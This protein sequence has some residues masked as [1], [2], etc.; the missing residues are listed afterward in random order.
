M[1]RNQI[2]KLTMFLS[3]QNFIG[4]TTEEIIAL[5]PNF[6]QFYNQFK[7][8][9]NVLLQQSVIQSQPILGYRE[10]KVAQQNDM[11]NQALAITKS[12]YAYAEVTNNITLKAASSYSKSAL[13]KVPEITCIDA[14][15]NIHKLAT[16]NISALEPYNITAVTIEKLNTAIIAFS[17]IYPVPKEH[18]TIKKMATSDIKKYFTDA[19]TQ[20]TTM[21]A[22][23]NMLSTTQPEFYQHYFLTRK[24]EKPA[25]ITLALKANVTDTDNNPLAKVRVTSEQITFKKTKFTTKIG[26]FQFKNLASNVYTFTFSKAGYI[27]QTQQVPITSGERTELK[28]ILEPNP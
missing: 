10:L 9:V 17:N 13:S 11:I 6:N 23:V 4:T 2:K 28:I 3:L 21:D 18:I 15:K 25:H 27:T 19:T 16:E 8:Y 5:M 14:C 20:T 12:I 24:T 22:L 1:N 26:N 7:D